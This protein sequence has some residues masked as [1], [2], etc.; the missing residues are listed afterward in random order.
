MACVQT[1]GEARAQQGVWAGFPP[2]PRVFVLLGTQMVAVNS[3]SPM[4]ACSGPW[5]TRGMEESVTTSDGNAESLYV[6]GTPG[7]HLR[8]SWGRV[9]AA[10][11]G[12]PRAQAGTRTLFQVLLCNPLP[13]PHP[14]PSFNGSQP[15]LD[16]GSSV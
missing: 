2:C 13:L 5:D 11:N 15:F 1:A 12:P 10:G 6:Q 4:A 7:G 14:K 3:S 16:R 8:L 9:G